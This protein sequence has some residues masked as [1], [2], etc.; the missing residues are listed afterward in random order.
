M[1]SMSYWG[2]MDGVKILASETAW[3]A[4]EIPHGQPGKGVLCLFKVKAHVA[5]RLW[6]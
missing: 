3:E 2:R 4:V 5:E 6:I 1:P